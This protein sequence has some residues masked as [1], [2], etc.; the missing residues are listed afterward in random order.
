MRSQWTISQLAK[1]TGVPPRTIRYYVKLGLLA[2]PDFRGPATIYDEAHHLRLR[3]IARLHDEEGLPLDVVGRLLEEAS[4]ERLREIADKGRVRVVLDPACGQRPWF[5]P[6]PP[7]DGSTYETPDAVLK[8][9]FETFKVLKW[10][11]PSPGVAGAEWRRWTLAPGLELH[12]SADAD[13]QTQQVA[14]WL[15]RM[16]EM[17]ATDPPPGGKKA[18]KRQGRK[19]P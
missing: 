15:L 17:C 16:A 2:R 7:A 14:M 11:E 1:D 19:S 10:D 18:A 5:A 13:Q 3:A 8:H 12:L 4:E 6:V 9:L